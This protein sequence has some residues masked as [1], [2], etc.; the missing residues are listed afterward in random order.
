LT[1]AGADSL[2]ST[3]VDSIPAEAKEMGIFSNAELKSRFEHVRE[4]CKKVR[5]YTMGQS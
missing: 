4:I 3:L 1:A 2:I 5:F